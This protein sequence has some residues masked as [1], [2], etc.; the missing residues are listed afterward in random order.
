MPLIASGIEKHTGFLVGPSK[1]AQLDSLARF[2]PRRMAARDDRVWVLPIE[3]PSERK[4]ILLLSFL[5]PVL[6]NVATDG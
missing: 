1:Y 3:P 4:C 2:L 5:P 6:A